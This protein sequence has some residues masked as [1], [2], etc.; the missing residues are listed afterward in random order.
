MPTLVAE[1]ADFAHHHH[2]HGLP[3]AVRRRAELALLDTY[4]CIVAGAAT[5]SAR[6][7]AGHLA[8][9]HPGR[10][11]RELPRQDAA[12]W[13]GTA[14]HAHDYDD[15]Q[16][17]TMVHPSTVAVPTALA[18]SRS[19]SLSNSRSTD[20]T[21]LLRAAA[22]GAE[23]ALRTG[24]AALDGADSALFERGLHMTSLCGTLG[25]AV[26]AGLLRGLDPERLA[27]AL[28]IAT[29]LACGLLEA[30]RTG[31]TV[32][33]V[34]AGWAAAAGTTAASLAAHGLTGAPTALEGRF[35]YL[36]AFV[37]PTARPEALTEE[38]GERWH[39]LDTVIKPY[40]TNGFTH[41]AVELAVLLRAEGIGPDRIDSIRLDLPGPTLRTVA[42]PPEAKAAPPGG[43]AAR[44]SAPFA[45]AVALRGGGGLGVALEDF[46]DAAVHDPGLLALAT[47][48]HCRAGARESAAFPGHLGATL[49]A[50][51][52]DG[53]TRTLH[54]ADTLGSPARPLTRAQVEAKFA[55][56]TGRSASALPVEPDALLAALEPAFAAAAAP[57]TG[58]ELM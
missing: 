23:T 51:L 43:Y 10:T 7:V 56:N 27:H 25:A 49:H 42:E 37:G 29:S 5:G 38:L 44:F 6:A 40:P 47:R 48:V 18:N 24:A 50:V 52:R 32:K 36:A 15:A 58:G 41:P 46:P 14:A 3:E 54:V 35:G 39:Y 12:L 17:P 21:S 55:A 34:H 19:N 57:G 16:L 28:A 30:N 26:T 8:E 1:L 11:L 45:V 53:T 9:Q 22:L 20:S 2:R 4:G 31:G 13:L 33:P